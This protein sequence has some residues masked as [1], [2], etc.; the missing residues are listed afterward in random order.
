[1]NAVNLMK[2]IS[3]F[4]NDFQNGSFVT[5]EELH[6]KRSVLLAD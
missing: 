6:A 5:S 4:E 1:M 2:V 3:I